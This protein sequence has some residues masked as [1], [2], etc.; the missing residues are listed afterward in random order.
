MSR[1]QKNFSQ[2][3]E[4]NKDPILRVLMEWLADCKALLEIGSGTGQHA[5]FFSEHLPQLRWYCS[6]L[7]VNHPSINAW[8]DEAV[9]EN[10]VRPIVLDVSCP[11]HWDSARQLCD[12]GFGA[13]FSANTAHIMS[14]G[15]VCRMF[16]GV[17]SLLAPEGVF[18]LY[19]PFNR[20]GEFT[21]PGNEAFD[22]QLR[23]S[24]PD[25]GIRDDR[26][27]VGL[28]KLCGL[29]FADDIPMPA[30]NRILVFKH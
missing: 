25:M 19:G 23:V 15:D 10:F 16:E 5:L 14:W 27:I 18:L 26:D 3:S 6:D 12:Q 8:L 13:M 30:N 20:N 28:A 1:L 2:A 24:S 21:S 22:R 11:A 9:H 17:S 7:E 29:I 4:N